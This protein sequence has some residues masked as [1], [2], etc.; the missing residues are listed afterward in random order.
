MG[1]L[2]QVYLIHI[3]AQEDAAIFLADRLDPGMSFVSE[4]L[5]CQKEFSLR[6]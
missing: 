1:A 6:R 5:G 3:N 4:V 2:R